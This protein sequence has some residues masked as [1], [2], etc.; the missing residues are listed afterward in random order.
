MTF[1]PSCI[2]FELGKQASP[3]TSANVR[4]ADEIPKNRCVENGFVDIYFRIHGTGST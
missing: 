3:S 2:S 4:V 1:F